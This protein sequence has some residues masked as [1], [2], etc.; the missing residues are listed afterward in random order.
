MSLG[1]E[2]VSVGLIQGHV[3]VKGWAG[4]MKGDRR[5]LDADGEVGVQKQA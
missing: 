3:G 5:D 1:C 2:G 4:G